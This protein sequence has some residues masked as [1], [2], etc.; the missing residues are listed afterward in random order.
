MNT[1]IKAGQEIL[2]DGE[3]EAVIAQH[4]Q[5]TG[6]IIISMKNGLQKVVEE[7]IFVRMYMSGA[8]KFKDNDPYALDPKNEQLLLAGLTEKQRELATM[9]KSYVEAMTDADGKEIS[10]PAE[11]KKALKDNATSRNHAKAPHEVTVKRWRSRLKRANGNLRA[12]L[13]RPRKGNR[14]KRLTDKVE[15]AIRQVLE[16]FY[17][18]KGDRAMAVYEKFLKPEL[19]KMGLSEKQMPSFKTFMT[20]VHQ[21]P[22]FEATKRRRGYCTA[23]NEFPTGRPFEKAMYQL[24]CAE[25]DNTPLDVQIVDK[26][27]KVI[28]RPYAT[29]IICRKTR[30]ILG[31]YL[32]PG[33]VTARSVL[34][35]FIHAVMPKAYVREK[36]PDIESDWPCYGLL[37]ELVSDNGMDYLAQDVK[38]SLEYLGVHYIHHK[39]KMPKNKGIVERVMRTMNEQLFH[40]VPGTTTSHY[41]TLT[42]KQAKQYPSLTIEEAEH[43]VHKWIIDNYHNS[44]HRTLR[45]TPLNKWKMSSNSYEPPCLPPSYE[46]LK[47]ILMV[48]EERTLQKNGIHWGCLTYQSEALANLG[49]RTGFG[50]KNAGKLTFYYDEDD[51]SYI[52]VVDPQTGEHIR[53]EATDREYTKGDLSLKQHELYLSEVRKHEGKVRRENEPLLTRV[54]EQQGK[55]ELELAERSKQSKSRRSKRHALDAERQK[56]SGAVRGLEKIPRVRPVRKVED[57]PSLKE[58]ILDFDP[59]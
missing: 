29:V 7:S 19:A 11:R 58:M 43:M 22:A 52:M 39:K 5:A 25:I 17:L 56:N 26:D 34:K 27:G 1:S 15:A 47:R 31:F 12:L 38:N 59:I 51:I 57:D 49:K 35:A 18:N 2:I 36:F 9:R 32:T 54:R 45:D 6:Q 42:E 24:Q 20:R 16:N 30:M 46:I 10:D 8:L 37:S 44:I 3:K 4:L 28:G 23:Q 21:I 53:A 41:R 14:N 55:K 33:P 13:D 50:S 48:P 40:S